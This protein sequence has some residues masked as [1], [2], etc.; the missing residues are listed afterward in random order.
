MIALPGA[1]ITRPM[2][3]IAFL[4]IVILAAIHWGG[5]TLLGHHYG[6][7]LWT[8]L[9]AGLLCVALGWDSVPV[10]IGRRKAPPA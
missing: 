7:A 6:D 5:G 8:L 10:T 4:L 1:G 2:A 3:A 9:G